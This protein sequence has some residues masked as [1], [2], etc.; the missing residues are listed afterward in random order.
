VAFLPDEKALG[1][2]IEAMK[3]GTKTYA[4]FDIAKLI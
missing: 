1:V 4:L 3:A 2:M